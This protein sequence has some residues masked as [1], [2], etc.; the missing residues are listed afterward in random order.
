MYDW[1]ANHGTALVLNRFEFYAFIEV[2]LK[3]TNDKERSIEQL[4]DEIIENNVQLI[5]SKYLETK[6]NVTKDEHKFYVTPIMNY[7]TDGA[8]LVPYFTEKDGELIKN[9]HKTYQNGRFTLNPDYV[10]HD[11]HWD[12]AY[13]IFSDKALDSADAFE[14]KPYA[15]YDALVQEFHDKAKA[16]LPEDFNWNDHI[17]VIDYAIYIPPSL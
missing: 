7:E 4:I 16:Y 13:A 3:K 8:Y 6:N 11:L 10:R 14:E 15:S 17:G 9:T 5:R 2:Y 12:D 1:K